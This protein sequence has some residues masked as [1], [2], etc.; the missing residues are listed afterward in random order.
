MEDLRAGR[1]EPSPTNKSRADRKT[2]TSG[3][4]AA[5]AE[6]AMGPRPGIVASRRAS[7]SVFWVAVI[8][9]VAMPILSSR[10]RS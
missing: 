9:A 6:D 8:R 3:V 2:A 7:G 5:K 10:S 4:V 1:A